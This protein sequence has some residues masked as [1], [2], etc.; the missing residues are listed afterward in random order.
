MTSRKS[1]GSIRDDSAVDPT[2]SQNIT[3]SWRRSAVSCDD[4]GSDLDL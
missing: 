1:S 2:R 4:F 3:V